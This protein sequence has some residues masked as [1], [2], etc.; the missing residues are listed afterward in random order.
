MQRPPS[1]LHSSMS[2]MMNRLF[3]MSESS[4]HRLARSLHKARQSCE[5]GWQNTQTVSFSNTDIKHATVAMT[6]VEARAVHACLH[7][8]RSQALRI[9]IGTHGQGLATLIKDIPTSSTSLFG[10]EFGKVVVKVASASRND[11]MH[12][13]FFVLSGLS[14]PKPP[15]G[16]KQ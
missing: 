10:G 16:M 13:D 12:G 5:E 2:R 14:R 8:L 3:G 11:K 4:T 6:N 7:T 9:G 15:K 1:Q